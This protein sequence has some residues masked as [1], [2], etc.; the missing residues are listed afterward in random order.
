MSRQGPTLWYFAWCQNHSTL[1]YCTRQDR[2]QRETSPRISLLSVIQ[3]SF[4]WQHPYP[5]LSP[6]PTPSED[7][8]LP[9][10]AHPPFYSWSFCPSW[11]SILLF[12]VFPMAT[13][14]VGYGQEALNTISCLRIHFI[15]QEIEITPQEFCTWIWCFKTKNFWGAWVAQLV[16]HLS[17]AQVMILESQDQVSHLVPCWGGKESASLSAPPWLMFTCC[18]SLTLSQINK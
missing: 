10:S 2:Q 3:G 11:P 18:S 9:D 14:G 17:S 15:T 12:S 1:C 13:S 5:Q 16:K 7:W 6:L 8:T 4:M